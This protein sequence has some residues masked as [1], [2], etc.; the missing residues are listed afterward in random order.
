LT[1]LQVGRVVYVSCDPATLA[2]D[3]GALVRGGYRLRSVT[4]LDMFPQT[5]DV[6]VV[7]VLEPIS[8]GGIEGR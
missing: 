8:T 4:P 1:A 6:E 3:L 7:A 5:A 2:R